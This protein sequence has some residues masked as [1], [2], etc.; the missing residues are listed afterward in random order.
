[1][2]PTYKRMHLYLSHKHI[3]LFPINTDQPETEKQ[4]RQWGDKELEQ[5]QKNRDKGAHEKWRTMITSF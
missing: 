4:K 1:M 2:H 5:T 3:R